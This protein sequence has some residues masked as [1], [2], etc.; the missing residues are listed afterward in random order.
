M[1]IISCINFVHFHNIKNDDSETQSGLH[2]MPSVPD[3]KLGILKIHHTFLIWYTWCT[4]LVAWH[5]PC[6]G[7]SW[8]HCGAV[9]SAPV[10]P[11]VWRW[12]PSEPECPRPVGSAAPPGHVMPAPHSLHWS[13]K[14]GL[15][16]RK[17][18]LQ[19]IWIVFLQFVLDIEILILYQFNIV[20]D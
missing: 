12:P 14:I 18:T 5:H 13:T 20:V 7:G 17:F 19:Y 4:N 1:F 16:R 6:W 10:S 11:E 15:D 9:A 8:S 2:W 3:F